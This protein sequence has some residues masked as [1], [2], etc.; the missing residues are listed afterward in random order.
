MEKKK[1]ILI[2]DDMILIRNILQ[3]SLRKEGYDI[4]TAD[5]GRR[6][7]EY[8]SQDDSPDFIILDITMPKL[9]GYGVIKK[10]KASDSTRH[11]PVIFLTANAQKKDVMKGME[12]GA[13]D[14][15]VK[16]FK[17]ADLLK[18]IQNLTNDAI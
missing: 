7:L 1:T 5:N 15:I 2:V 9:D 11:I 12:A 17:F 6:A 10:L 18:R 4:I 13:N 8:A 14:Y 3:F 16:P